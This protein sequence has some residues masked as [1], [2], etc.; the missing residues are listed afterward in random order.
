[1]TAIGAIHFRADG[2]ALGYHIVVTYEHVLGADPDRPGGLHGPYTHVHEFQEPFVMFAYM[3]AATHTL[4][5]GTRVLVLPQRQTALVAK[6][7]ATLDVL[8][9]GRFA[10]LGVGSGWNEPEFERSAGLHVRPAHRGQI[11]AA[12]AVVRALVVRRAR[13][14]VPGS[15][16]PPRGHPDL[17][18]RARPAVLA[19]TAPWPAGCPTRPSRPPRFE[20]LWRLLEAHGRARADFGV[21][22]RLPYGDGNPDAWRATLAGWQ[23]AGAT[24]AVLNTMGYGFAGP[25]AHLAALRRFAAALELQRA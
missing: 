8:S 7:A 14:R 21:E 5:F 9:G 20:E 17:D 18:R 1:M 15:P 16:A 2:E 23:A 10:R 13:D 6:Q 22:V 19:R 12:P 4:R 11:A 3:A 25:D 24:D